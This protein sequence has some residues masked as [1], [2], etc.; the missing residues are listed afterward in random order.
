LFAARRRKWPN[1]RFF[2]ARLL[3]REGNYV[4]LFCDYFVLYKNAVH[5]CTIFECRPQIHTADLSWAFTHDCLVLLLRA[6]PDVVCRGRKDL[7]CEKLLNP[8]HYLLLIR[9][10]A[11]SDEECACRASIPQQDFS[12]WALSTP[13]PTNE[14]RKC[15]TSWYAIVKYRVPPWVWIKKPRSRGK[16]KSRV[17]QTCYDACSWFNLINTY[18]PFYRKQK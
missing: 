14:S 9:V 2:L 10:F 17:I 4:S 16:C 15:F 1:G 13:P 11:Y 5:R 7:S 12:K 18:R 8:T 6:V 3:Q